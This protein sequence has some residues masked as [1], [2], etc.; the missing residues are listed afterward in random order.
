MKNNKFISVAVII[1][2]L[3]IGY[4]FVIYLPQKNNQIRLDENLVKCNELGG[5]EKE[6]EQKNPNILVDT[7]VVEYKYN[8]K[9]NTC[10]YYKISYIKNSIIRTIKDLYTNK[11]IISYTDEPLSDN[12]A[13]QKEEVFG[14]KM[15][16]LGF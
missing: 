12:D 1:I 4:Y 6:F 8:S 15:K 14:Q 16:E 10:S 9:L 7:T 11:E 3:A 2:A 13:I 5:K